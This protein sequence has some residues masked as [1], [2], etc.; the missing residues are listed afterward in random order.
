[1]EVYTLENGDLQ[2]AVDML[3]AMVP[4]LL[5]RED[6]KTRR[7]SVYAAPDEQKQVRAIIKQLDSSGGDSVTVIQLKKQEN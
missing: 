1:L 6:L 7:I 4:G 2:V 3:N 5:I